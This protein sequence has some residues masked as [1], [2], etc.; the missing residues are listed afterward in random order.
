MYLNRLDGRVRVMGNMLTC[1][2][3]GHFLGKD[4][5]HGDGSKDDHEI[6]CFPSHFRSKL[7]RL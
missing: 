4:G 5:Y 2:V 1:Q 3:R 7:C 6:K